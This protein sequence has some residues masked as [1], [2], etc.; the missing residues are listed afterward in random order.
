MN[1]ITRIHLAKTPYNIETAAHATLNDYLR[2]IEKALHADGDAM[3]EIESRMTELLS[4]RGVNGDSV[5]TEADV[6]ALQK[7]LGD[8]KDF[9]GDDTEESKTTASGI[10]KR[11]MRDPSNAMIAGVCSGIAAYFGWDA[12]WVR[13]AAVILLF[14]TSGVMIPVYIVLLIIMPEAKTAA[15]RLEMAGAPVTLE[16]LKQTATATMER[17]EPM[18]VKIFRIILGVGLVF[19]VIAVMIAVIAGVVF[20]GIRP[21]IADLFGTS[22]QMWISVG[23]MAL[24]GVM[25][26]IFC[27]ILAHMVLRKSAERSLIIA[28]IITTIIGL[29]SFG[30]GVAMPIS[31]QITMQGKLA[32][33]NT[34][35]RLAIDLAGVTAL[36]TASSNLDV[37]YIVSD[38]RR[39]A[40]IR[41]NNLMV[42]NPK[43]SFTRQDNVLIVHGTFAKGSICGGTFDFCDDRPLELYITG[44][45][46]DTILAAGSNVRYE[47]TSQDSLIVEQDDTTAVGVTSRGRIDTL[48]IKSTGGSFSATDA[49][50]STVNLDTLRGD[51]TFA[52]IDVLNITAQTSS[53]STIA[54]VNASSAAA[55]KVNGQEWQPPTVYPC[56][57]I[58]IFDR[59]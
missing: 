44:P 49:T 58:Q 5:I 13:V 50:I 11:L 38:A 37:H 22:F 16:T 25:L 10:K 54:T 56:L 48:S 23:L 51:S 53:C 34:T 40:T 31:R 29:G 42:K 47:T 24:G 46:L 17:A 36:K 39:E 30:A 14:V 43:V 41:Y 35:D 52:N 9:A 15:D 1:E 8:P 19:G 7:Q 21:S 55:V 33:T 28:L 2:A 45:S 20:A 4:E 26:A 27:G 32:T 12:V 3:R 57:G 18:L 59:G 6:A